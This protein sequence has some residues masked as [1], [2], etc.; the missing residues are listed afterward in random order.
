MANTGYPK[1]PDFRITRQG[2]CRYQLEALTLNAQKFLRE[3]YPS[4]KDLQVLLGHIRTMDFIGAA[5][6]HG[7]SVEVRQ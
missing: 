3:E 4:T 2:P 7:M 6:W 5:Y 1:N